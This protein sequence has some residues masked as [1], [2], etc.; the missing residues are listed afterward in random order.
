M[1]RFCSF[2]V[3]FRHL[4]SFSN[5]KIPVENIVFRRRRLFNYYI[6]HTVYPKHCI[7]RGGYRVHG[8]CVPVNIAGCLRTILCLAAVTKTSI[9]SLFFGT[10]F[11]RSQ[12]SKIL[13]YRSETRDNVVSNNAKKTKQTSLTVFVT[14]EVAILNF[15]RGLFLG[16]GNTKFRG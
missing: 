12:K 2:N 11:K 14:L 3:G 4:F 10:I 16:I 6:R 5:R 8:T 1:C 13:V 15:P 9:F 7:S